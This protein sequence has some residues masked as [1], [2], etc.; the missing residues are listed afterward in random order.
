M[1]ALGSNMGKKPEKKSEAPSVVKPKAKT[2]KAK[3]TK[4][5]TATKTKPATLAQ[6]KTKQAKK[7]VATKTQVAKKPVAAK[8]TPQ[9]KQSKPAT[10]SKKSTVVAK[11]KTTRTTTVKNKSESTAKKSEKKQTLR[12]A[13]LILEPSKRRKIRKTKVI[14]EGDLTINNVDAFMSQ[15]EPIFDDYDYVDFFQREVTALDLCH[16]QMLY[17]FQNH[18]N[19]KGKT[20]TVNSE[21]SADLKKVVTNAGFKE[22]MFIPKLV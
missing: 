11:A 7:N 17:Y 18:P 1:A 16:I 6:K 9:A 19:R 20:V 21:L 10:T 5:A 12:N 4:R 15:I 14:L 2:V 13:Q 22:F 3:A 8:S